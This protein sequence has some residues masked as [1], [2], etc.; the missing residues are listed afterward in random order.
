VFDQVTLDM[1]FLGV[2]GLD[3]ERGATCANEE[4]AS[5]NRQMAVRAEQVVVVADGSKLG[6]RAFARICGIGEVS[7]LVTDADADA[8]AYEEAGIKVVRA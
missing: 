6:E 2:S 1:A 7:M 4:E 8:R 3:V 5:I